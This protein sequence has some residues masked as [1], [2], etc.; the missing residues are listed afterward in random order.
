MRVA[1]GLL[2]LKLYLCREGHRV[3]VALIVIA[4]L[5]FGSA[6]V[7]FADPPQQ[8]VT[9]QRHQ[10]TVE[11]DVESSAVVT[12]DT[13]LYERGTRLREMPVY[14]RSATPTLRPTLR[15][16]VPAGTDVE[17]TQRLW[18]T[19]TAKRNGGVFWEERQPLASQ[20]TRV[21]DGNATLETELGIADVHDR[22][23]EIESEVANVGQLSVT[24]HAEVE[25][26]TDRYEGNL[27]DSTPLQMTD[28]SYWLSSDVSAEET[29]ATPV[30]RQRID[31]RR[32][33][34]TTLPGIGEL[35]VP[36]SGVLLVVIGAVCLAGAGWIRR[37][38]RRE[39]DET[40]LRET[41]ARERFGEWISRGR[42]PKDTG[43]RTVYVESLE[44]LVDVAIDSSKRVIR[45]PER[46]L[47]V[48]VDGEVVYRYR[49]GEQFGPFVPKS[50][51]ER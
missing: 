45:D 8:T 20:T 51:Q 2:R 34:V 40:A 48:V 32:A 46:E 50:P 36:D 44:D 10:Q 11:M 17:V 19:Y 33:T 38:R 7:T 24:L 23:R 25:Y 28:R 6:A 9:E 3:V 13:D 29:H 42:V 4:A 43:E 37:F 18:V 31:D 1:P 27:T 12:G 47:Y 30:T 14:L 16:V 39:I 35:V 49:Q 41:L 15:T 5:A 26:E 21:S 22:L